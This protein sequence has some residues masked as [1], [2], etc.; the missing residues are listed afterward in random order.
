[1]TAKNVVEFP[2]PPHARIV[3]ALPAEPASVITLPVVRVEN[4]PHRKR[5]TLRE[6]TSSEVCGND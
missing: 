5:R 3:R 4:H 6:V 2:E 1:M